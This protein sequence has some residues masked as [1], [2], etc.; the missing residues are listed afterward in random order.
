[1]VLPVPLL[2]V[3]ALGCGA[4]SRP[5]PSTAWALGGALPAWHPPSGTCSVPLRRGLWGG[6]WGP[7]H[8][9]WPW[10]SGPRSWG[11]CR[12]T[13]SRCRPGSAPSWFLRLGLAG[14]LCSPGEATFRP[15]V[16][17][18]QALGRRSCSSGPDC[19]L[20]HVDAAL[21][22]R[23]QPGRLRVGGLPWAPRPSGG[24]AVPR[25][26]WPLTWSGPGC[27]AVCCTGQALLSHVSGDPPRSAPC[28]DPGLWLWLSPTGL[29]LR[30]SPCTETWWPGREPGQV[31]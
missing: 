27:L 1:M 26:W 8:A 15:C 31:P 6:T 5:D 3:P 28:P 24:S 7:L 21:S 19:G 2:R 12:T 17:H 4:L 29:A 14:C 13:G 30:S 11:S 25:W 23:R 18:A 20:I 22:G 16:P 10:P 9:L